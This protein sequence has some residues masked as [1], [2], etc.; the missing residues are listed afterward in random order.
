M[1]HI[2]VGPEQT[3]IFKSACQYMCHRLGLQESSFHSYN[4]ELGITTTLKP[5][6]W[7]IDD[8]VISFK[9]GDVHVLERGDYIQDVSGFIQGPTVGAINI[10]LKN[11]TEHIENKLVYNTETINVL[12]FSYVWELD[13]K[14]K[15]KS[16]ESLKLPEKMLSEFREDLSDFFKPETVSRYLELGMSHSRVYM[17]HGPP[18]TGKTSLIQ[19]V[20]T[21]LNMSLAP[22]KVNP[23]TDD[24][25]LQRALKKI[26]KKT[27]LVLEDLDCLFLD[28]KT[29]ADTSRLT[30]SGVLNAIDGLTRLK[31]DLLIFITTN[32]IKVL[33]PAIKRRVDYFV[34]FDYCTIFN[35]R[36]I[37]KRFRPEQDLSNLNVICTGLK[38]TPCALQKFLIQKKPLEQL[39]EDYG[40]QLGDQHTNLYT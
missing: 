33:D 17:L 40:S 8:I 11:S 27:I 21:H 30:F 22:F 31:D 36:E 9:F 25:D 38:L 18:G 32:H 39:R 3:S 14:I 1:V 29:D 4:E 12:G 24:R 28:R 26:P 5:G 7:T 6:T 2:T 19:C 20:A 23:D 37:V 15:N 13:V 16:F 10:F 35:V 34:K